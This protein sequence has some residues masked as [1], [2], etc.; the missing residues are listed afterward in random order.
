MF[1]TILACPLNIKFTLQDMTTSEFCKLVAEIDNSLKLQ[2]N[3]ASSNFNTKTND[4]LDGVVDS[5]AQSLNQIE[6]PTSRT[7]S[8]EGKMN[9]DN[10]LDYLGSVE[11]IYPNGWIP[12][13]E[14]AEVEPGTVKRAII[15]GRD[16][17]V[18]RSDDGQQVSVLS[19]YCTHMGVHLG[20]RGKVVKFNNESCIRCPF[21]GWTYRSSD[22]KCVDIP[23]QKQANKG[24]IPTQ[25]NLQSWITEEQDN[26]IYIW[27]HIDNIDPTWHLQSMPQISKLGWQMYGRSV[28]TINAD[29]R[30]MH[31]NGGDFNHFQPVHEVF[32]FLGTRWEKF[33]PAKFVRK[34]LIHRW[35]PSWQPILKEDGR[36]SHEAIMKLVSE[37]ALFGRTLFRLSVSARQVGPT[38]VNLLFDGPTTGKGM[39]VMHAIPIGGR[40]TQLVQHLYI[41]KVDVLSTLRARFFFLGEM[42]QVS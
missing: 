17:I 15:M 40:R 9:S 14:S 37:T 19:A 12:V 26:F 6:D 41:S 24:R 21:H 22:G 35:I 18:T 3:Y 32:S 38:R 16:V 25:A 7:S 5:Q 2:K 20:I 28:H 1:T 27:Y 8:C 31:E 29:V 4:A 33:M 42:A 39:L 34:H 30:D 10:R 36:T 11:H 23:Y 13:M